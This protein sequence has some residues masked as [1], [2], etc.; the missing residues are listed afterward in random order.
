MG[1][2][3]ADPGAAP[4]RSERP[5]VVQ[6]QPMCGEGAAASGSAAAGD[7]ELG[8]AASVRQK[9]VVMMSSRSRGRSEALPTNYW[10]HQESDV[11]VLSEARVHFG[12]IGECFGLDFF[13]EL[14]KKKKKKHGNIG[15]FFCEELIAS[16]LPSRRGFYGFEGKPAVKITHFLTP[17]KGKQP[18][19][20]TSF[21]ATLP[22][23]R[24]HEHRNTTADD[25]S[26]P[27]NTNFG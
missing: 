15:D 23:E 25:V 4:L 11:N 6:L 27:V 8:F 26:A 21:V 13:L 18:F 1:S 5:A 20:E 3:T 16:L 17:L 9:D 14:K 19:P 2:A 24:R 10:R 22:R 7:P 12:L